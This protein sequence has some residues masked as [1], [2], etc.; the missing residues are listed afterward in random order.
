MEKYVLG[1]EAL[2][3]I[4]DRTWQSK[5]MTVQIPI[6]RKHLGLDILISLG[7]KSQEQIL[8]KYVK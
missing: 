7:Q 5:F 6:M 8:S 3:G 2:T 4:P 1:L